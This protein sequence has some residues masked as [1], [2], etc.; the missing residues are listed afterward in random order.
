MSNLFKESLADAK[1]L[2]DVA[3]ENAMK[4]I[5]E[6]V[7]PQIREFIESSLLE[8]NDIITN[9]KEDKKEESLNETVYLDESS[10]NSLVGLLG[11]DV[12]D[13]LTESK[14]K[15]AL[16]SAIKGAAASINENDRDVLFNLTQKITQNAD[17]L[18]EDK[19]KG[20]KMSKYLDLDLKALREAVEKELQEMD[21]M[22]GS[23]EGLEENDDLYSEISSLLEQ[24]DDEEDFGD[25]EDFEDEEEDFGGE[26]DFQ[27]EDEDEDE[28]DFGG[29]GADIS[30][31]E[32]ESAIESLIS[33]LGLDLAAGG[34]EDFEDEDEDEGDF[35]DEEEAGDEEFGEEEEELN[36][37]VNKKILSEALRRIKRMM[38]ENKGD[39]S[40]GGKGNAKAGIE[41][42]FGGKGKN[43]VGVEGSFGG[44][45]GQGDVFQAPPSS[46]KKINEELKKLR[47]ANRAQKTQLNKYRGAVNS[48]R[49]QLE[50]LN[51][52]SAKLLFVN[53]LMQNKNIN[54]TQQKSIIKVLDEAE[55]LK[56]A[57]SLYTTLT[58]TLSKSNR[59]KQK[60]I[61]ESVS[62][63]SART[64]TSSQS[65]NNPGQNI[66]LSRWN[67]LAGL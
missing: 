24:E 48:L 19:L 11:E 2:R 62:G 23:E 8:G 58:S 64:T 3:V 41:K 7:K 63:S 52:F 29:E 66:Q 45:R 17:N 16:L 28:G 53:K 36:E 39:D 44:G 20:D 34:E 46:L 40:F 57:K 35:E 1:V 30:K 6:N 55:S 22:E 67:K 4:A 9:E 26:E 13:S 51:L 60:T 12:L 18:V 59:K 49:E 65:A 47:R 21:E 33:D 61:N 27:A 56:E 37:S 38:K 54:E 14:S 15:E 32:V 50:D 31:E 10:L 5:A 25:E 42:S 43:K